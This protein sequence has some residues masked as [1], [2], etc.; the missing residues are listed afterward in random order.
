ML[1]STLRRMCALI[2][3]AIFLV[4]CDQLAA[5]GKNP[6]QVVSPYAIQVY[7]TPV[8]LNPDDVDADQIGQLIF[9]GGIEITSPEK[10]FGG[11]SG[12]IVS[13]NGERFLAVSD[14]GHWVRGSLGYED[15]ALSSVFGVELAPMLDQDGASVIDKAWADAE[16]LVGSIDGKVLV[17]FERNH[18]VWAYDLTV[19]NFAARPTPVT[20]PASVSQIPSNGGLEA[21][22]KLE[23]GSS[24]V[25]FSERGLNDQGHILGWIQGSNGSKELSL[26]ANE[27]YN[28]T[29]LARLHS[30]D[31]L[32]LERRFS[33]VGGVGMALRRIKSQDLEPNTVI[34][35]DMLAEISAPYTIDNMEGLAVRQTDDGRTLIYVV[36]DDNFNPLQRTILMMFELKS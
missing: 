3:L 5:K 26:V 33:L 13:P 34:E 30:G 29:D 15:A 2:S 11:L 24:I 25:A 16:A 14:K 20:M 1:K 19:N 6:D 35:A 23:D 7:G 4:A 9:R 27:P 28:P 36:S 12:L 21:V 32:V 8:L 10:R 17:A 22:A 18:R 31:I